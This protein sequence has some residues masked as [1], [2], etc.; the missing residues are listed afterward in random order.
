MKI[1]SVINYKGGTA[2]TL[3]TKELAFILSYCHNKKVLMIDN[4]PQANISSFYERCT[5]EEGN[6]SKLLKG[7]DIKTLIE[8]TKY[9]NLDIINGNPY[10]MAAVEEIKKDSSNLFIYKNALSRINTEYDY[11]IIDN[12]PSLD[13]NVT[14]AIIASTDIIIPVRLNDWA[15]QGLE[16]LTEQIEYAKTYNQKLKY[17]VL[18]THYKN[19]TDG[20]AGIEWLRKNKYPCYN[21]VIRYSPKVENSIYD[22]TPVTIYSKMSAAARD[23][24]MLALEILEG[25]GD[26][27]I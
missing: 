23:Y 10:T 15:L 8:P 16:F 24:K 7:A 2:K 17:K 11:A 9:L 1:I 6:V 20:Q 3:T 26:Y 13:V 12:P 5:E 14:N 4:D 25:D 27:G 22:K 21:T 18:V 19:S